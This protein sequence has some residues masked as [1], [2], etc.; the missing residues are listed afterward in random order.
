MWI[1]IHIYMFPRYMYIYIYMYLYIFIYIHK[2]TILRTYM[3]TNLT[4]FGRLKIYS[5][6]VFL[7]HLD[8]VLSLWTASS[9]DCPWIGRRDQLSWWQWAIN[10]FVSMIFLLVVDI[11]TTGRF[12]NFSRWMKLYWGFGAYFCIIG[13]FVCT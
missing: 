3:W 5:V 2:I 9:V 7:C 11:F 4:T 6:S 13:D 1:Y 10:I 12:F 8:Q